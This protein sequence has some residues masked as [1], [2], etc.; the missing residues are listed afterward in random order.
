MVDRSPCGTGTSAETALRYAQGRLGVGE[1]F[2]TESIIGTRFQAELVEKT[3]VG[4]GDA[5]FPAVIPRVTGSAYLT[6]F[7]R[8]VLD[9]GDPFPAGF[10]LM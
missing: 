3:E 2:V 9:P 1:S 6:G 4:K 5:C 10:R 8:F 7:H